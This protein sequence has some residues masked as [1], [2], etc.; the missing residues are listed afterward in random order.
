M[1]GVIVLDKSWSDKEV[2]LLKK[3]YPSDISNEKLLIKFPNR[4]LSALAHKA[5]NLGIKRGKYFPESRDGRKWTIDEINFVCAFYG[6]RDDQWILDL[7]PNRSIA[8]IKR[9]ALKYHPK[10]KR[11]KGFS[12]NPSWNQLEDTI[13]LNNYQKMTID[14]LTHVL[15]SRTY[16]G[17]RSRMQVLKLKRGKDFLKKA[18]SG[19]M[20]TDK[21]LKI[22]KENKNKTVKE[23]KLLLPNRSSDGIRG[24]LKKLTS[25]MA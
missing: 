3:I 2:D 8:A 4:S 22:L 9:I 15:P 17:I 20:W 11:K 18:K 10:K 6:Q 25:D 12:H 24:K 13:L 16:D 7:I 14:E 5:H 23:L 21:E 19:F 1:K